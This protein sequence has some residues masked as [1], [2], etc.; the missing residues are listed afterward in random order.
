MEVPLLSELD[1]GTLAV[2]GINEAF[3]YSFIPFNKEAPS[4]LV[5]G[6]SIDPD[7]DAIWMTDPSKSVYTA[8]LIRQAHGAY[9]LWFM[10]LPSIRRIILSAACGRF[11]ICNWADQF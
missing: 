6:A 8:K 11:G 3:N 9:T 4:L 10:P 7:V 2:E 1:Y 5:F